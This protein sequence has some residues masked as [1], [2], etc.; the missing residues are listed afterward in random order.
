MQSGGIFT[1][2]LSTTVGWAYGHPGDERPMCGTWLLPTGDLG[3]MFASLENE[4]DD[5]LIFHRP[6]LILIEAPLPPTATS[7]ATTWH[8]QIGEDA[9]VRA[10]AYRHSVEVRDQAVSTVRKEVLGTG[11][12]PG[13][14]AKAA[15]LAHCARRGWPVPDHN[16]ADACVL[17]EF[18]CRNVPAWMR[19][20]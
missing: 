15:V 1:L 3:R 9:C 2:D 11:R 4:L 12:F 14:D 6:R 18:A 13:G 19:A 8:H 20:A 10:T 5:A 17:W 7:N 16:A